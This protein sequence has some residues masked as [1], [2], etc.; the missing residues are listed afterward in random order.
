MA[1]EI[2]HLIP[3][4][5]IGGVERAAATAE[6]ARLDDMRLERLFI[7]S[8]TDDKAARQAL[9]SP[10]ALWQ[11]AIR[12]KRA[13]PDLI[14][15]SLWR[16]I[17][18]GML[19]RLLGCRVPT[20]LFL[21]NSR[22][23]HPVDRW[24]TRRAARRVNAIWADSRVTL[25]QRLPRLPAVPNRVISYLPERLSPART[26]TPDPRP[27][28]VFWGRL[29]AQKAPLRMLEVFARIQSA[30]SDAHL[31]IVG[32]DGGELPKLVAAIAERKL[33]DAVEL[34]GAAGRDTIR[35]Y[36]AR[37]SFYLQT[38]RYE[39]MALSVMEAMQLG[40]VPVVTPVGEI[41][42]YTEHNRNAV[43]ID[44]GDDDGEAATRDILRLLERPE[45]WR[46]LRSAA[47]RQWM[48]CTLY[49]NDL[50]LAARDLLNVP[51]HKQ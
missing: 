17:V 31:T 14:I 11:A 38:S 6:G 4:D 18:V 3:Y 39:G 25:E 10:F 12:L 23:A 34:A 27:D 29:S 28:F 49:S 50:M 15:L 7:V 21:H 45:R 30:R 9:R 33:E 5:G 35:E 26:A 24:I 36:A 1:C 20:V 37:A 13:A 19:A 47:V 51:D 2:V 42:S 46:A 40:L 44:P 16:S 41:A 32:P 48:D 8:E 22:D 43:W